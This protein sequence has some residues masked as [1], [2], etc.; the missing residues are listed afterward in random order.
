MGLKMNISEHAKILESYISRMT[1]NDIETILRAS[2]E[3]KHQAL[4]GNSNSQLD[5][6]GAL[7]STIQI[8]LGE[9]LTHD[10]DNIAKVINSVIERE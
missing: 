1:L 6:A 7:F 5:A 4:N 10:R 2:R 8:T 9:M 3:C